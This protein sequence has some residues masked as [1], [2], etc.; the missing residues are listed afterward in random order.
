MSDIDRTVTARDEDTVIAAQVAELIVRSQSLTNEISYVIKCL[1]G[2]NIKLPQGLELR[3][4]ELAESTQKLV[5][6]M[7]G[8]G[9]I[10]L[11]MIEDT[12]GDQQQLFNLVDKSS[13]S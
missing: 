2:V 6:L 3:A 5:E 10:Q 8:D 13:R 4:N 1:D 9:A 7:C 12:K 11:T